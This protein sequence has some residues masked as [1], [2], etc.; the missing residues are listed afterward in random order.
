MTVRS[1][2]EVSNSPIEQGVD[3]SIAYRIKSTPWGT[4]PA[5]VSNALW[6]ISNSTWAEASANL[7]GAPAVNGDQIIT[8]KVTG[9]AVGHRYRLEVKFTCADGNTYECYAII[10]AVK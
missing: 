5:D 6:D 3:E 1:F 9:L 7:T 4:A 2:R 8:S 10:N